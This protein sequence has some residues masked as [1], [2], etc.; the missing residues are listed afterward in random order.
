MFP[1]NNTR[2][3]TNRNRN[4]R[5]QNNNRINITEQI[6]RFV[7]GQTLVPQE[8]PPVFVSQPWNNIQLIM[9]KAS[10]T[11]SY[12]VTMPEILYF[13]RG[14]AGFNF[15]AAHFDL[16][17]KAIKVWATDNNSSM[18]LFP[19]DFTHEAPDNKI[20]LCRI[21]SNYMKNMYARA[22]YRWPSHLCNLTLSTV[23]SANSIAQIVTNSTRLEIHLDILW[24]G[25][26]TASLL[27]DY[28]VG[29]S[30]RNRIREL[31]LE[32][33]EMKLEEDFVQMHTN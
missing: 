17:I 25:A 20:E 32:L 4:L 26:E 28:Q 10:V 23:S 24:K 11:K 33:E 3:N 12:K 27:L 9:R 7:N 31:E 18:S 21:D 16:R 19:L 8:Q 5:G 2:V 29:P 14:Q 15:D 13:L 6:K 1:R 30:R 22:G